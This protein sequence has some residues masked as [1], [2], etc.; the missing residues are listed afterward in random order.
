MNEKSLKYAIRTDY[1]RFTKLN[2]KE[3]YTFEIKSVVY[4]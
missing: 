1:T 4:K 2:K 3:T